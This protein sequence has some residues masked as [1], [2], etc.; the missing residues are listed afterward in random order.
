MQSLRNAGMRAV[1]AVAGSLLIFAF[2]A[3]CVRATA[4]T[5]PAPAATEIAGPSTV[6]PASPTPA[7]VPSSPQP[8]AS[9]SIA[10]PPVDQAPA[11]GAAPQSGDAPTPV[12]R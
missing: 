3:G 5:S 9:P 7:P 6:D 2:G 4:T 1:S 8:H 11:A 10:P 12:P